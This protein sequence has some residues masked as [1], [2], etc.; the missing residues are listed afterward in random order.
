MLAELE[1]KK[2]KHLSV[3]PKDKMPEFVLNL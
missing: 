1:Q 2:E 3:I